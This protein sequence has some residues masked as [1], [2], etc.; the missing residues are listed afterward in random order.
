MSKSENSGSGCGKGCKKQ[1]SLLQSKYDG[2]LGA[3]LGK[4]IRSFNL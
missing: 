3:G 1:N 2:G 4:F